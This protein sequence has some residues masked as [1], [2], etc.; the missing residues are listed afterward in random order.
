MNSEM[1][2]KHIDDTT[3]SLYVGGGLR[4]RKELVEWLQ[5]HLKE[6]QLCAKALE[7]KIDEMAEKE[8]R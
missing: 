4:L 2:N 1:K 6:C 8:S 7:Q 5:T 3:M